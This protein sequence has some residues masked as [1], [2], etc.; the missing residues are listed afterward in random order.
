MSG[1]QIKILLCAFKLAQLTSFES[2][3][4]FEL[5]TGQKVHGGWA[6]AF[7]NVAVRKRMTHPFHLA[8]NW[9]TH[10]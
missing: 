7:Q 9:A 6:G 5:G 3:N 1:C 4:S 2:K 10:P 8:Q